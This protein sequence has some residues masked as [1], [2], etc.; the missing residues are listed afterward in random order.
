MTV[1]FGNNISTWYGGDP[2]QAS[3]AALAAAAAQVPVVIPLR[4]TLSD[5]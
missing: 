5:K 2:R 1:P 4:K 3:I